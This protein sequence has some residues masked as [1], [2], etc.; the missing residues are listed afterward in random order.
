MTVSHL[1][2][3]RPDVWRGNQSP[4]AAPPVSHRLAGA[5]RPARWRRLAAWRGDRDPGD[6]AGGGRPAAADAVPGAAGP[7]GGV[8]RLRRPAAAALSARAG[9][10]GNGPRAPAGREARDG[11]RGLWAVEQA[12]RSG[13]CSAV[14]AWPAAI[15]PTALRRL[16]LAAEAGAALAFLFRAPDAAAEPSPAALRLRVQPTAD[17]WLVEVLKRRG[18]WRTG[19]VRLRAEAVESTN[20]PVGRFPGAVEGAVGR[21]RAL[22]ALHFPALSL[23]L[24]GPAATSRSPSS[25]PATAVR[26]CISPTGLP[27][28]AGAAR[29]G[30][31]RGQGTVRRAAGPRSA[32]RSRGRCPAA[33][34]RLAC[35]FTR[36]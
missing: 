4:V 15:E 26:W 22:L 2:D 7:A 32:T 16:Q 31:R 25:R 28:A 33:S 8:D 1:L 11:S 3:Q 36:S 13:S 23:D 17:G 12:L 29:T 20:P 9:R 19:P 5:G 10:L 14:L 24:L 21:C 18:G 35:Q 34:R 6:G 30:R 27:A